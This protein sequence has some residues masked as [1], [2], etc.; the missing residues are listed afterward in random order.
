MMIATQV[1]YRFFSLSKQPGFSSATNTGIDFVLSVVLGLF[2]RR[3]SEH[4]WKPLWKN[5]N[6]HY[7]RVIHFKKKRKERKTICLTKNQN[8]QIWTQSKATI[9]WRK[10][11]KK[12]GKKILVF[13]F[14]S[15]VGKNGLLM[16]SYMTSH[17]N[18]I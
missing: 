18:S 14:N 15:F 4:H 9:L 13:F 2:C 7:N 1:F 12:M 10:I 6:T 8:N 16:N 3:S 17:K 11:L 5:I